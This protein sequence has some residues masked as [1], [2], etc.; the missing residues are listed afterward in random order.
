MSDQAEKI[1][2]AVAKAREEAAD[3][4]SQITGGEDANDGGAVLIEGHGWTKEQLAER[5]DSLERE[6]EEAKVFERLNERERKRLNL[7]EPEEQTKE[8]KKAEELTKAADAAVEA[9]N[10]G[11]VTM[12]TGVLTTAVP[13]AGDVKKAREGTSTTRAQHVPVQ[14]AN[15]KHVPQDPSTKVLLHPDTPQV[16]PADPPRDIAERTGS[17]SNLLPRGQ[18]TETSKDT[19]PT[20]KELA[21]APV[22][23]P[24]VDP[25]VLQ[26]TNPQ[27][28]IEKSVEKLEA[29]KVVV[30][31][32]EAEATAK[33]RTAKP[34]RPRKATASKRKTPGPEM[35]TG[36]QTAT[37][38]ATVE[39][40]SAQPHKQA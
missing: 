8:E 22:K 1:D 28:V 13:S 36:V 2:K 14:G 16:G 20:M 31:P 15:D 40:T 21:A 5:K 29:E 23:N 3:R 32:D 18:A 34:R 4:H 30:A 9:F 37:Q 19:G 25:N 33:T 38:T 6:A 17:L 27:P 12:V 35:T 11:G 7:P 26:D 10:G 24:I 39:E